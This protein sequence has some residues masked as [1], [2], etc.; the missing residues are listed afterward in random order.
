MSIATLEEL[1]IELQRT[2]GALFLSP[3]KEELYRDHEALSQSELKVVA[4]KSPAHLHYQRRYPRQATDPMKLGTACHTA[5]LEPLKFEERYL[6]APSCDKRTKKGKAEWEEVFLRATELGKEI[7]AGD[8][9]DIPLRMREVIRSNPDVSKL[10]DDG[11]VERSCFGH[12][13]GVQAKALLDYYRPKDHAIVDLK[14]TKSA[15]EDDFERDIR[16]YRY[17][18]QACWYSDLV[19]E[20]TGSAPTFEIVAIETAPPYCFKVYEIDF[21]LMSI[22]RKEIMETVHLIRRC[23][24]TGIWPGYSSKTKKVR[25][26]KWEW[27]AYK[28][29]IGG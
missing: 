8:D 21:D 29:A 28:K 24:E 7:L 23:M 16:K 19:K 5:I 14:S 10:L 12:L 15:A 27:E 13:H 25:A 9:Y 18:W 11:V 4:A 22:A 1:H 17:H 2:S 6:K 26:S 3:L 20:L